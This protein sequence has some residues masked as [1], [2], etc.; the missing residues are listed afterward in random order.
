M[1]P[2]ALERIPVPHLS[3]EVLEEYLMDRLP[4]ENEIRIEEHFLGCDECCERLEK[5]FAFIEAF[6]NVFLDRDEPL[7]E[8]AERIPPRASVGRELARRQ[9]FRLGF[10]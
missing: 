5:T 8:S 1:P 4:A 2:T 3:E 9:R 7:R 6:Q 10:Q